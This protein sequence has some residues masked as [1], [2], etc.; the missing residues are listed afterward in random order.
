ME[1]IKLTTH[2]QDE[3]I[4]KAMTVLKNG[5]LIIYPTET[6]YGIGADAANQKAV[7]TLLAY[8][9][10]RQDKPMS[11]A[12]TSKHMAKKFVHINKVAEN[13]Y[14]N[15]L[16]G[17]ITVVSKGKGKFARGVESS[18]G[19]QGV[20]VSSHPFVRDLLT[21]YKKPITAT[22]A[23]ASYKKT[24]YTIAD[25]L[26]NISAKQKSLVGLIID[27]GR[28]HKR[29]PSTVVDTTLDSIHIVREGSMKLQNPKVFTAHSLAETELF[30]S[31]LYKQLAKSWGTREIVILLQGDL[32]AGKTHFTKFLAKL[33]HVKKVITSPTFTLCNKYRG[34]VGRKKVTLYHVDTYRMYDPGEMED[35]QP[36]KMFTAPNVVVIEWANKVRAYIQKYLHKAVLVEILIDSPTENDRVFRYTITK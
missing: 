7:N 11:V 18:H 23:N 12:V 34:T 36:T 13:I 21:H 26:N 20:R 17:P 19:T 22:S 32:G 24:P 25:I 14:D 2:N 1:T 4:K 35:L 30:V 29:K 9:T 28:L 33:L 16:P 31:Q 6:C 10:K 8:K 5:G 15:F 27:A 3:L